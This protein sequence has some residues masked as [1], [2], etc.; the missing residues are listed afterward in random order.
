MQLKIPALKNFS[1]ASE[2]ENVGGFLLRS[3]GWKDS[4]MGKIWQL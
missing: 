4:M 2:N 3:N 1:E